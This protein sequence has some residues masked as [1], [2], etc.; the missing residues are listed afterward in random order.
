MKSKLVNNSNTNA[1]NIHVDTNKGVVKLSGIVA[2]EKERLA[3]NEI[4]RKVEGV[5][6]VDNALLIQKEAKH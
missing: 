2:T 1:A 6:R 5:N 4:A 3:A